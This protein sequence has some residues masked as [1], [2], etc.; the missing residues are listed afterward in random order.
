MVLTLYLALTIVGGGL[1]LLAAFGG[2]FGGH[3]ADLSSGHDIDVSSSDAP[4]LEVDHSGVDLDHSGIDAPHDGLITHT[5]GQD[6][7]SV[8][9]KGVDVPTD[10]S[11]WLPFLTLRFWI[12]F[13]ATFGL[14]GLALTFFKASQEPATLI[15][16]LIT[17]AFVATIGSGIWRVLNRSQIDTS[18]KSN[19][20][21][22]VSGKLSVATRQGSLGRVRLSVKGE[23]IDLTAISESGGDIEAGEEV[24]VVGIEGSNAKVMPMSEVMKEML[25]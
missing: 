22:G 2:V 12:Y 9:S 4:S 15:A 20:F 23:W 24:V 8:L 16:S 3:D 25:N 19:D 1:V 10:S 6:L 14:T 11:I 18:T 7:H 5:D 17:A 21:L 13:A